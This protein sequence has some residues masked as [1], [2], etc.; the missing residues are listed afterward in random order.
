MRDGNQSMKGNLDMENDSTKVKNKIINLANGID[1]DD[2][3]NLAQ[4]KSYTDSHQNN[5]YLRESFRF[6]KNF[7]DKAEL[8]VQSIKIPNHDHHDLYVA[9]VEGSSSDFVSVKLAWV[10]LRM[11]NSL[12]AGTYTALFEISSAIIPSVGNITFLNR[13]SLIQMPFGDNNVKIMTLDRD[14]QTT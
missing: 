13:E 5:Y 9:A 4:L 14:Y 3:V 10:R 2:A 7:G 1:N 6:Y 8:T 12:P 11:T